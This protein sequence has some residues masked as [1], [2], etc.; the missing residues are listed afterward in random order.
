M[1]EMPLMKEKMRENDSREKTRR[2]HGLGQQYG[3][4]CGGEEERGGGGYR[5]DKW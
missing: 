1:E 4:C 3:E 2:T 5:K